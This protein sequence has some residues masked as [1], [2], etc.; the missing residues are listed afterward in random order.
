MSSS[1]ARVSDSTQVS[2]RLYRHLVSCAFIHCSTANGVIF[3]A[4][5]SGP[6]PIE[7]WAIVDNLVPKGLSVHHPAA[8]PVTVELRP[9]TRITGPDDPQYRQSKP[10]PRQT[11]NDS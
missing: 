3:I 5:S 10:K 1:S 4:T 2:A 7:R 6:S 9:S 11:Q 8:G